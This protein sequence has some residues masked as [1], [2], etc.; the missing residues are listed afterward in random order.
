MPE[1]NGVLLSEEEA[2]LRSAEEQVS[3]LRAFYDDPRQVEQRQLDA[4]FVERRRESLKSLRD[5]LRT[6]LAARNLLPKQQDSEVSAWRFLVERT[7][8][9]LQ[10]EPLAVPL[11]EERKLLELFT[12][13]TKSG[14]DLSDVLR[15]SDV[16][17]KGQAG[18]RDAVDQLE[19][20]ERS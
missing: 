19:S 12:A 13:L 1:V 20:R 5:V 10:D 2:L 6:A 14:G 15:N 4:A 3:V 11:A 9:L 18:A 8:G 7:Q 17:Q 16:L